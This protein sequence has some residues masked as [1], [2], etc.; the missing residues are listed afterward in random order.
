MTGP[1]AANPALDA[2][3]VLSWM[4][5]REDR[6]TA[7]I[8]AEGGGPDTLPAD[9]PSLRAHLR[10]VAEAMTA[11]AAADLAARLAGFPDG[12][13]EWFAQEDEE[14]DRHMERARGAIALEQHLQFGTTPG[15]DPSLD[16]GL[17]RRMRV[18]AWERLFLLGLEVYL[19]PAADGLCDATLAWLGA[20]SRDL[21]RL[22]LAFDRRA[23]ADL[24]ASATPEERDVR[25][26][27]AAV[28]ASLRQL[29][30]ALEA[31]LDD[32]TGA[33]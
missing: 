32:P 22:V 17:E 14:I 15:H 28:R 5:G 11:V 13:S 4:A 24:P 33:A 31:T 21:S 3:A 2:A 29:I 10:L 23:K 26:Q 18:G 8:E 16:A 19:G 27:H 30:H 20:R 9:D 25:G 7:L 1:P 6:L 12:L